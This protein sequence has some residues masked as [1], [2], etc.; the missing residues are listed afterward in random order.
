MTVKAAGSQ[1]VGRRNRRTSVRVAAVIVVPVLWIGLPL[2]LSSV[3][4]HASPPV[5]QLMAGVVSGLVVGLVGGLGWRC[6]IPAAAGGTSA[7]V[8]GMLG[9]WFSEPVLRRLVDGV[10]G[11]LTFPMP[12]IL[13][14]A[15]MLFVG[16]VVLG[17]QIGVIVVATRKVGEKLVDD[18]SD[19]SGS[20]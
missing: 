16:V 3:T 12:L 1:A 5:P 11:N 2:I 6:L 14:F 18:H 9:W 13:G 15:L 20:L 4:D 17:V 19:R 10:F 7:G 8:L